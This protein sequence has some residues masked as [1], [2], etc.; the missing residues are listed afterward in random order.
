MALFIVFVLEN[1]FIYM[2]ADKKHEKIPASIPID[3]RFNGNAKSND[4]LGQ[5]PY[6]YKV[7]CSGNYKYNIYAFERR[8]IWCTNKRKHKG[9]CFDEQLKAAKFV[10]KNN[11]W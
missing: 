3:I 11:L 5:E 10:C 6:R 1:I 7:R 4:L 8:K 9:K 2:L